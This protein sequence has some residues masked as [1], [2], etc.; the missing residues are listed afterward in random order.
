MS[1]AGA[2]GGRWH[3]GGG[4]SP[5]EGTRLNEMLCGGSSWE[6]TRAGLSLYKDPLLRPQLPSCTGRARSWVCPPP[7]GP[8]LGSPPGQP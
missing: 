8:G 6:A 5:P 4:V 2:A 3:G 7:P 1:G